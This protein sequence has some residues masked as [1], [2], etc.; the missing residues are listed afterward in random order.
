MEQ[1]AAAQR[2]F[3][4]KGHTRNIR[5]RREYLLQLRSVLVRYE[6]AMCNAVQADMGRSDAE[7]LLMELQA[8]LDE[9][10]YALKHLRHWM[11][12]RKVHTPL[13]VAPASS[14]LYSEPYGV[15]L[16][17]SA[18]NFPFLQTITP[19][20]GAIA[21][22][23][24]AIIKP[25][26]DAPCSAGVLRDMLEEVFPS[27]YVSV[28][29]GEYTLV[30]ELLKQKLDYVFFTG[31]PRVGRIIHAACTANLV[32]CTLELGGKS[33]AIVDETANID[34]AAKRIMWAK[35]SNAGQICISV[36]HAYVQRS[37]RTE[38]IERCVYWARQFY[39]NTPLEH[40]DYGA[41]IN[42]RQF[43]RLRT[44]L[45]GCQVIYGGEY[46]DKTRKIAPT[47]VEAETANDTVMQEE[48]FGPILPI[49]TFDKVDEVIQGINAK[50]KPLALYMFS[51]QAKSVLRV[52]AETSS[53]GVTINDTMVHAGSVHLPFGGVGNSG[54]GSY[55]GYKTFEAFSHMKPVMQRSTRRLFDVSLRYPPYTDKPKKIKRVLRLLKL[56][57]I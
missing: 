5:Q 17:V 16:I 41:I 35:C 8:N 23:N 30:S 2:S 11:K 20:V 6:E 25:S 29:L 1:L 52:I 47:L 49:V 27:E 48:I 18:W 12:P 53:G 13:L 44:L 45:D 54:M 36:D 19:L 57:Q 3:F 9:I 31:S 39:G 15:T 4:S 33:P 42:E 14:K 37:V 24:T 43:S 51:T 34:M 32:P 50:E 38:F 46:D 10:D 55:H 7:T 22:G 26:D 56:L 28:V 40:Q 21:A